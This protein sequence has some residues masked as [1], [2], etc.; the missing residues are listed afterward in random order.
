MKSAVINPFI[1]QGYESPKYFCD[2]VEE[3]EKL[4]SALYNGRNIT[5][6]SPR[7]MG[8]TGLI[9][10]L[11]HQISAENKDAL[12]IYIDIF[13]SKNQNDFVQMFGE[14]VMN[15]A[16]SKGKQIGRKIMELFASMR[17]TIGLDPLT[18]MPNVT[19]NI[20]TSLTETTI[21][22]I[23]GYLKKIPREI[24]IAID[25][26][27]QVTNYPEQ[28]TEALL[29]SQIQF[30]R[31]VH[32]I[33]SGSRQ[34]LMSE[35]FLSPQR[36]FFQSTDMMNLEPL[37][38]AVYYSFASNFFNI[39][40]WSLDKDIFRKLYSTFDGHTWYIQSILNRLY[41]VGGNI[42][43]DSQVNEAI[44]KVSESNRTQ[45]ETIILFLTDNQ[46]SVIKAIAKE[47]KVAEPLSKDFLKKYRLPSASSVKASLD[48]LT[49]RELIYHASDGYIIYDRFFNQWLKRI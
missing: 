4:K 3:T 15:A 30:T 1:C 10:H 45:Y 8:K 20:D 31:N 7:R 12:C 25:E 37:D 23:F 39:R 9:W 28:G 6:V 33:F 24:F 18:G 35:M 48:V 17:P 21:K 26:F 13:P 22:N 41:E 43:S 38:I 49:K 36:P 40:R 42:K 44:Y 46:T 29:R 19:L 16:I 47:E 14:A 34:H 27:Q 2:R 5:L 11:F 32:F